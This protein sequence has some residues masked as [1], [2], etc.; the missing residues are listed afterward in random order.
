MLLTLQFYR[1]IQSEVYLYRV[2][3]TALFP[4]SG[5]VLLEG[6]LY[7]VGVQPIER[8]TIVPDDRIRLSGLYFY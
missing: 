1:T 4:F 5:C 3:S 2:R 8:E 6:F 7:A